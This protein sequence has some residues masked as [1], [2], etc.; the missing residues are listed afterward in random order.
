MSLKQ[1]QWH[2]VSGELSRY[3]LPRLGETL[4]ALPS[5]SRRALLRLDPGYTLV[6][7]VFAFLAALRFVQ[8]G[9]RSLWADELF[10]VFWAKGG[11]VHA[12][13]HAPDETNPP[14]YYLILNL[15]MRAFGESESMVRLFSACVSAI[16]IP[17]VYVLGNALFGRRAGIISASLFGLSQWHLHFAQEARVF[18]LL[19]CTTR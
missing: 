13:S 7:S 1:K 19:R 2:S 10:S 14:L 12:I 16:T 3:W 4:R 17:L 9:S 6:L 15:W 5:V 18:A 8:I 11:A